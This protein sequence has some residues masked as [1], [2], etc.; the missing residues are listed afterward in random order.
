MKF[1][2]VSKFL[3]I[4]CL[5]LAMTCAILYFYSANIVLGFIWLFIM[6]LWAIDLGLKIKIEKIEQENYKE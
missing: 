5:I 4:L 2:K 3:T 6:L 1:D